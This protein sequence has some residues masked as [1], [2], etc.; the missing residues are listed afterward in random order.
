MFGLKNIAN[1]LGAPKDDAFAQLS[2]P[3][4]SDKVVSGSS[5]NIIFANIFADSVDAK[6]AKE[7]VEVSTKAPSP[8][9][10][11]QGAISLPPLPDDASE[12]DDEDYVD[13]PF[14]D[15]EKEEL[16]RELAS[17]RQALKARM[18]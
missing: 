15:V 8:P 4:S 2:V 7:N 17:A 14:V 5:E 1:I 3:S 9:F 12:A 18:H 13:I 6:D 11:K 16:R 10:L